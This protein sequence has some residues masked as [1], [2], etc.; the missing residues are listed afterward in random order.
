ML[1][2]IFLCGLIPLAINLVAWI[3]VVLLEIKGF[4]QTAL[5]TLFFLSIPLILGS[6]IFFY[7]GIADRNL[8][9]LLGIGAFLLG[10]A[11]SLIV[12][13]NL[14]LLFGGQL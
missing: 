1:R 6:Y 3:V 7:R 10:A 13:V 14:K 5:R 9:L 2:S 4:N 11:C 8:S 12:C